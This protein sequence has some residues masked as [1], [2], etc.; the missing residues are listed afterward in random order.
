MLC[1]ALAA[2]GGGGRL[3]VHSLVEEFP[4][5]EVLQER[6]LIDV[7]T[8]EARRY[9][10]SGWSADEGGVNG[11]TFAWSDG[12]ASLIELVLLEARDIEAELRC[13][14][15]APPGSPA[16]VIAPLLNGSQLPSIELRPGFEVHRFR[17]PAELQVEGRNQLMLRYRY[18]VSPREVGQGDDW[19]RLAVAVD[20]LRLGPGDNGSPP[21]VSEDRKWL[22]LPV[23]SMLGYHVRHR[24]GLRLEA[25][26]VT[27][28]G[29]GG[30]RIQCRA[31][32][33]DGT[34]T[35]LGDLTVGDGSVRLA[36][37]GP[38]GEPVRIELRSMA[39]LVGGGERPGLR[40]EN[41]RL[42]APATRQPQTGGPQPVRGLPRLERPNVVIYL[43]DALRADRLGAYGHSSEVSPQLDRFARRATVYDR[44]WAQTS[45]TRPSVASI[46]TGLR[47]EVHGANGR[48]DR[49]GGGMATLAERFA[50][51]G[52]TTAA[53]VANPN[54]SSEFGFARGFE[55]FLLMEADRR[56]SNEVG[57][58]VEQWLD[59]RD[60]SRPF[61]LYVHTVDPHLP[62]D[63]PQPYRTRF[64]PG[65]GRE[66]L[67]ST[68]V[69]GALLA[70]NLV[71]EGTYAPD[72][73]ALYDAEVAHN[74]HSFGLLLGQLEQRGL[75]STTVVVFLS[76][77]GEEFFDH[78]GWIHGR[79]LY[80]EVLQV[81]LVIRVPGQLEGQ[82]VHAPVQHVDLLPT[83]LELAGLAPQP[84]VHGISLAGP[85]PQDRLL[86]GF[87]DLDGWGG[88]SVVIGQRHAIR[89]VDRGYVGP[90]ELYD[91]E[92]DPFERHD[93]GGQRG[94]EAGVLLSDCRREVLGDEGRYRAGEA[95]IDDELRRRLEALGYL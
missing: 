41:P 57:R 90:A 9:L 33:V 26:S 95:E 51:A 22:E 50:D 32:A 87:L 76:D 69:V 58:E 11:P 80:R 15:F 46:F 92:T 3:S 39:G 37:T 25:D 6:P 73:L 84:G 40:V 75:D 35:T 56:R 78:G 64:A 34:V 67:G 82:R 62:Y 47:P 55:R 4:L 88:W 14:P 89:H 27:A 10:A 18:A 31:I 52:Y 63:P 21:R 91:L 43:V 36:V 74:D 8:Q 68:A 44:A 2:C 85:V 54:I 93:L 59:E 72:L 28:L 60:P 38:V 13:R 17:L 29:G 53:V 7:G 49:L 79:T 83:L 16:Q 66:D 5:A 86:G 94:V 1:L 24:K 77:H 20:W 71:D 19:R 70:R 65:T 45:W 12:D 61:L 48:L 23:G 42:T 81:P 30:G